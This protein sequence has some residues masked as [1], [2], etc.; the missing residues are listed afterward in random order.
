MHRHLSRRT[1]TWGLALLALSATSSVI[2]QSW[3]QNPLR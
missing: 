2:A 3:P 1:K